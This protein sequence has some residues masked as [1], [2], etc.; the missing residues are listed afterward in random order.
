MI[1]AFSL[2]EPIK[3][4]LFANSYLPEEPQ[5]LCARDMLWECS[6]H[7]I[8][9]KNL[10]FFEPLP[11]TNEELIDYLSG[12]SLFCVEREEKYLFFYPIPLCEYLTREV[13][14]GEYFD[15]EQYK[16]FRFK[17]AAEDIA[18]LRTYKQI[19]LTSRGTLEF[20][21]ACTQTLGEAMTVAAFH[22][23]LMS[24]TAA[25]TQLLKGGLYQNG[26][27]PRSLREKVNRRAS[28][29]AEEQTR[30][31][32]LATAVLLLAKEGLAERGY[33]EE[34]YLEPLFRRAEALTSP[35][36]DMIRQL[37]EG[38]PLCSVIDRYA[39]L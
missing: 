28:L 13:V 27:T 7:G 25:L 11:H 12:V 14:E 6:T 20:R 22:L 5:L 26:G 3:A 23:G 31:R 38:S 1:E 2:A 37:E 4:L 24:R 39:K 17:P 32:E 33:A 19:D 10:G 18:T 9:P 16:K 29:S 30:L 35:A 8:N 15:G 21:S 36:K 34:K